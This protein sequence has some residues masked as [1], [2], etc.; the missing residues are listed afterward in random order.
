MPWWLIKTVLLQL[1]Q[2]PLTKRWMLRSAKSTN[3]YD[4]VVAQTLNRANLRL[5]TFCLQ[6][7]G[8]T[9]NSASSFPIFSVSTTTLLPFF[10]ISCDNNSLTQRT[11][12][13]KSWHFNY[14]K[15]TRD[16]GS[17]FLSRLTAVVPEAK[18]TSQTFMSVVGWAGE[19]TESTTDTLGGNDFPI[20]NS[21]I[22]SCEE[23]LVILG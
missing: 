16:W 11:I 14:S 4:F 3:S 10:M 22:F 21:R 18:V 8:L 17:S 23:L 15:H 1:L 7:L 20:W 13:Q 12:N 6:A 9:Q 5:A 19:E 2:S